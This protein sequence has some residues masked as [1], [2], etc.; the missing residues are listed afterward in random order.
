VNETIVN[1]K[2][3]HISSTPYNNDNKP[4]RPFRVHTIPCQSKDDWDR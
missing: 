1:T 3:N 4:W 2:L